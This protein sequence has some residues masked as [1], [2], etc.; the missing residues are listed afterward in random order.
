MREKII[1]NILT[2]KS[3]KLHVLVENENQNDEKLVRRFAK[4]V[5][6]MAAILEFLAAILEFCR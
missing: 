4:K 6:K 3:T 1:R 5:I 2:S